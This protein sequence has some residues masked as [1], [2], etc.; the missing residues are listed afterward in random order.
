VGLSKCTLRLLLNES[1]REPFTG[2]VV[3]L[4]KQDVWFTEETLR[5]C[6]QAAGVQLHD[7]PLTLSAKPGPASKGYLSDDSMLKALGFTDYA[8]LDM[9]DYESAD[10]IHNLNSPTIPPELESRFDVVIDGGTLEH[11]FHLPN[12]I[13]ALGR[14]VHAEGRVIHASPSSNHV[15]HGFYM[16]SPTFFWDY[17]SANGFELPTMHIVRYPR[18]HWDRPWDVY[19]YTPGVL[20]ELSFGGLE[21]MFM[22]WCVARRTPQ[23]TTGVVPQQHT[24]YQLWQDVQAP[25]AGA[26]PR[27]DEARVLTMGRALSQR[28]SPSQREAAFRAYRTLE[29]AYRM[30]RLRPRLSLRSKDFGLQRVG[31]Y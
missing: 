31:R 28:L 27:R 18:R 6:A 20:D 7:V 9:S 5:S 15:D 29:R 11:V 1:R 23:S 12:A 19:Q 13:T 26:A 8:A 16:F 4:G 2:S 25:E 24:Y 3:V 14:M 22:I 30:R 17:Y 10:F 21:G